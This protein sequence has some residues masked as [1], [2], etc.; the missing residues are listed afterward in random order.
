MLSRVHVRLKPEAIPTRCHIGGTAGGPITGLEEQQQVECA[1]GVGIERTPAE[2]HDISGSRQI[3][4]SGRIPVVPFS[5]L[6][7]T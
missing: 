2:R 5:D 3:Y 4:G 1:Q 7:R 6:T